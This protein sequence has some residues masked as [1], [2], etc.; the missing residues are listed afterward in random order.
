MNM[1]DDGVGWN[2]LMRFGKGWKL[3]ILGSKE[4][5]MWGCYKYENTLEIN[6]SENIFTLSYWKDNKRYNRR[7][8]YYC[9]QMSHSVRFMISTK[10]SCYT[11][12]LKHA[13][14]YYYR[15]WQLFYSCRRND[16]LQATSLLSVSLSWG[17]SP[18]QN[19]H[20]SLY[21]TPS[22]LTLFIFSLNT[23]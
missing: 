18:C 3:Y 6:K 16:V 9:D 10:A 21:N 22:S 19:T 17:Y 20:S 2:M 23:N 15:V 11:I 12:T 14:A 7:K 4:D 5:K 13:C 1:T 8:K